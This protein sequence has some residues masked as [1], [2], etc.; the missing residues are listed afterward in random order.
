MKYVITG[1]AGHIAK[2]LTEILLAKG[3]EVTLVA[4]SLKNIRPLVDKGAKSAIGSVEDVG[5]LTK[6][7][8]GADAVFTLVPP[9]MAATEW[10]K[11]IAQ[12]G[13]NYAQ[14]IKNA[15]V[16]YV[17]NLSSIGAHLPEG[18]GP[19]S[20]IY[21][22]EQALNE[23][24]DVHVKHLR[25]A[26]FYVNLFANVDMIKH[27]GIMGANYG[28]PDLKIVLVHPTDIADVAAQEL[29]DLNFSGQSIRYIVSDE[30]TTDEIAKIIG[31]EIGKPDLKWIV[32]SDEDAL[33][34]M[35]QAGLPE[36]VAKNYAE[37]N[38][39]IQTGEM[40]ADY[41]KHRPEKFEKRKLEDFAKEFAAVYNSKETVAAH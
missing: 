19:V 38:H 11:W 40:F 8:T 34:G 7:F 30:K 24:K 20:G 31:T 13:K 1:G 10:K 21:F 4:R 2:P 36:E 25:P 16:K 29:S 14:A 26:S 37:M 9:N 18:C 17:V 15:G 35:V 6:T 32:F 12:I 3:N 27:A 41:N 28:G 5:F 23:L 39:S 33:K 22:V